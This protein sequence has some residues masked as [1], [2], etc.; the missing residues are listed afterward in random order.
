MKA[1]DIKFE[2]QAKKESTT[3]KRESERGRDKKSVIEIQERERERADKSI[4]PSHGITEHVSARNSIYQ[5]IH[6]IIPCSTISSSVWG[7]EGL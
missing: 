4:I 2:K 5:F 3:A 7:M 6:S 1:T